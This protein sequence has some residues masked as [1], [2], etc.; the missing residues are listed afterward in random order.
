MSA[1]QTFE[2][3]FEVWMTFFRE[4]T[5]AEYL[6]ALNSMKTRAITLQ[7]E[8]PNTARRFQLSTEAGED[9]LYCHQECEIPL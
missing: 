2:D 8:D 7:E 1:P 6:D 4:H 5:R 9:V 3:F